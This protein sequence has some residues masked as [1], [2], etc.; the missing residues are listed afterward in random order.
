IRRS[1]ATGPAH[2]GSAGLRRQRQQRQV[3]PRVVERGAHGAT[4]WRTSARFT[5]ERARR[6]A[7]AEALR[8]AAR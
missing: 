2:L 8:C 3:A 5:I 6:P 7:G 1:V 4:E